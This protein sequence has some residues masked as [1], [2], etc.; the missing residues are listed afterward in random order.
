MLNLFKTGR[1]RDLDETDLFTTL[2][3]QI[4]SSLGDKL[5]K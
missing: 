5:E 4:S 3:D 1:I 2:D